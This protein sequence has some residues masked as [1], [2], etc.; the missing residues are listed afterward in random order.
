MVIK[1]GN[2]ASLLDIFPF[3]SD[4]DKFIDAILYP[5]KALLP[6]CFFLL[7]TNTKIFT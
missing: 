6:F 3:D 5:R 4:A 2:A 7:Y 1:C